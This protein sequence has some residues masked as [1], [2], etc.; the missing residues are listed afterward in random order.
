MRAV[1]EA[2]NFKRLINNSKK[3]TCICGNVLMSYIYLEVDAE[4]KT[5]KA[6][7][8]DGHRVSIEYSPVKEADGSFK[9]YVRANIPKITA[10]DREVELELI[11]NRCYVTV[12]DN[13]TGFIQPAGKWFDTDKV[14]ND[15][16]KEPVTASIYVDPKL[17]KEALESIGEGAY[18]KGVKL[19]IRGKRDPIMIRPELSFLKDNIKIVLPINHGGAD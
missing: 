8:L 7:A 19:E 11:E 2:S 14:I 15:T 5:I 13:I 3:F 1:I 17:L 6:E 16:E 10:K 9:C 18:R 4:K 12:G